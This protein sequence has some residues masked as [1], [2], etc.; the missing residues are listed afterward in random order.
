M[1]DIWQSEF[2]ANSIEED[3]E[4][5]NINSTYNLKFLTLRNYIIFAKTKM[6]CNNR[7]EINMIG[8]LNINHSKVHNHI[9]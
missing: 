9:F 6:E 8:N 1:G 7:S 4:D 5:K 3:K 2:R